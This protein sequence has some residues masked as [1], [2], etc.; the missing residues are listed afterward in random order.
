MRKQ[1]HRSLTHKLVSFHVPSDFTALLGLALMAWFLLMSHSQ[2]ESLFVAN[3]EG[4]HPRSGAPRMLFSPPRPQQV[5]D[6]VTIRI[7]EQSQRQNQNQ[8]QIQK[9]T[10]FNE[11][12]SS[13]VN[14]AVS[15]VLGRIGLGGLSEYAEIPS[16][17]GIENDNNNR[18]QATIQQVQVFSDTVTCQVVQVLPNGNLLVQGRKT[19]AYAKEKSDYYVS[20]IVNPYFL[21]SE[22][23]IESTKVANMQVIVAG[24]GVVS[25]AQSVSVRMTAYR[26]PSHRLKQSSIWRTLEESVLETLRWRGQHTRESQ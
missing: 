9:Q 20:G 25:R 26:H 23:E 1:A 11:T 6:L 14:N 22:N 5:G 15:N 19:L 17:G 10:E 4:L 7:N 13:V 24:K 21:N 16:L 18:T 12:T 3:T 8:I 2:A